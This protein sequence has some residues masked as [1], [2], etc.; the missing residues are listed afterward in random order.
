MPKFLDFG[1]SRGLARP[2]EEYGHAAGTLPYLAPDVLDGAAPS[3]ASDV[4]A[5]SVVIF[6]MVTGFHPFLGPD[7]A[8]RIRRGLTDTA[9]LVTAV[10]PTATDCLL[11]LLSARP[12]ERPTEASEL[13]RRLQH[14][15]MAGSARFPD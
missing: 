2:D 5:L 10:S 12:E 14:V 7:T 15:R 6:E 11:R 13:L 8:A 4:W 1:L 9:A 3:A